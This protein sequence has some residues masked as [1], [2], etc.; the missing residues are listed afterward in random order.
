MRSL[1]ICLLFITLFIARVA[2]AE[3]GMWLP[4]LLE[5]L[6]EKEMKS[7]GMKISAKDIYNINKG[8]LKD[9]IVSLGGFCTGE[10]ISSKGLVLTNHHCGFDAIQNHSTLDNNY[11]RD[12][13]WAKDQGSELA[14]EKL[15]VTFIIRIED[16][17]KAILAGTSSAQPEAERQ[18]IIDKNIAELRKTVKKESYQDSFIRGFFENNQYYLFITERYN[19]V[20]LVGAPPSSIGNFGKDTDNWM[21]PRHT[22]DF[23]MFRIYAG[24]DNKP[25][26]YS[27][28]NVPYIPK[29]SL[30]ISLD[31]V[32]EGD[33]TMVFGFPGRTTE[34]L[35]SSAVEQIMNLNDPL[36]IS[37]RDKALAVLDGFMRKDEGIKIQYS[38]KYASI[39]NAWKKWQGE[40]LGLN[41]TDGVGKKKAYEALFQSR[42]NANPQWRS[43]YGNLL[44]ELADANEQFK[45][46]NLARDYYT[47]IV[48]RIELSGTTGAAPTG[49]SAILNNLVIAYDREGEKGVQQ[50]LAATRK[51][52]ADI[53]GEYS[54]I[55]DQRLF[56]E[57]MD[58][59]INRQDANNVSPLVKQWLSQSNNDIHQLAEKVYG[60]N[61]FSNKAY[62]DGLLNKPPAEMI[63]SIRATAAYQLFLDVWKTYQEKVLPSVTDWQN[64]VNKL[65]RTY[66]AAQMEVMKEKKF[67]PDANSTL[68]VTYGKVNGYHA[69]DAV[70]YDYYSYLDGVMEKYKPGDYEFDV[71]LKLRQLYANKDYGQYGK[72]GKMPVTFIASNHTTGGNSGSPALDAYGN[73][74]GLN[75]DRVWEGTM[76]DIN[77]DPSICRNIMVD[78]RYVLFLID[79]FAGASHLVAEMKLVRPKSRAVPNTKRAAVTNR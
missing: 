15:F 4:L 39:S 63:T 12:G 37:I 49:I 78:I 13:F 42:V 58:I 29:K 71:P 66:M 46:Y 14:N 60:T 67:Y 32:S 3:E 16:V 50:R 23:S 30:S 56:E 38:A 74:V 9:A 8:S 25:A 52:L 59:Y 17:S 65:Q 47:E 69:R 61:S 27:P 44:G 7:L 36:K 76:S 70:S 77:Y 31:G 35:H 18:Q 54:A 57:L 1:R 11:I 33:F 53:Y 75:F 10:I 24:K 48:P 41:R 26:E 45:N 20:R 73:L 40:V 55:V 19:D 64:K 43:A 34:Y 51:T 62:T 72:N 2:S 28:D 6:N 22:G 68:R 21:W 79:K 5:K